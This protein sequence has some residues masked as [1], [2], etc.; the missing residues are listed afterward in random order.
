MSQ[1]KLFNYSEISSIII[2]NVDLEKKMKIQDR[3][4]FSFRLVT[5]SR[6]FSLFAPSQDEFELWCHVFNWIVETNSFQ[7]TVLK[8]NGFVM[9]IE[10]TYYDFINLSKK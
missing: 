2:P 10:K 7:K 5:E 9:Q 4:S 1:Y 8:S 3:W 6:E